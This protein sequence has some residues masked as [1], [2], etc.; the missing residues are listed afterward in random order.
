MSVRPA[1]S[2]AAPF[3]V[4]RIPMTWARNRARARAVELGH[5]HALPLAQHHL[6]AA[7]LQRQRMAEQ[8]R[9]EVRVGVHAIAIGMIRDRCA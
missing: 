2:D 5:Q 3:M 8:H 6:A 4:T 7:D 9:A 1:A